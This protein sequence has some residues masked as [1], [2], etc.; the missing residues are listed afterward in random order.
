MDDATLEAEL[1]ELMGASGTAAVSEG[2]PA[3]PAA[4]PVAHSFPALP[5]A[6]P[7]IDSSASPLTNQ[8]EK[9][10]RELEALSS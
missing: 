1:E 7:T 6:M 3:A 2:L 9:L 5:T 4:P 10:D 8:E